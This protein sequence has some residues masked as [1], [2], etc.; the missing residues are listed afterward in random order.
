MKASITALAQ[1]LSS[2]L[3]PST[4]APDRAGLFDSALRAIRD[5]LGLDATYISEFAKDGEVIYRQVCAPAPDPSSR[6][7][8]LEPGDILRAK[9]TYCY[10]ISEG[11]LPELI[12]DTQALELSRNLPATKDLQIGSHIG[13]PLQ[14]KDGQIYGMLCGYS[15]AP[16]PGLNDRDLSTMRMFANLVAEHLDEKIRSET[17]MDLKRQRVRAVLDSGSLDI[18][19]QPIVNLTSMRTVGFEALSRFSGAGACPP[20]ILFSEAADVGY[21]AELELAA[22]AK[23]LNALPELE[24]TQ[25]LSINASPDTI[26]TDA[27]WQLLRQYPPQR[28]VVEVTEHA[29]VGCY[30]QLL[31]ALKPLRRQGTRLAVDDAGAGYASMRHILQLHPDIIKLDMSIT[32]DID[33]SPAHRALVRALT[34]FTLETRGHVVA[35]GIETDTEL[36]VLRSL[37]VHKGQGYLLGRP[38]TSL[39]DFP[40]GETKLYA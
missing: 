1:G 26:V 33:K 36:D 30:E 9:T 8:Q 11:R 32:R 4:D 23:A 28:I 18:A 37:G 39:P 3:P 12:H 7:S 35:E 20:D 14:L 22:I 24:P 6:I 29:A 2:P 27:F 25:F 16:N 17:M 31:E 21:L 15:H 40:P 10:H 38:Q 13:V 34:S 5:H 19:F